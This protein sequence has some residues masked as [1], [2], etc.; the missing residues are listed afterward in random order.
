MG[1]SASRSLRGAAV[2]LEVSALVLTAC[3]GLRS[4]NGTSKTPAAVAGS[5][6]SGCGRQVTPGAVVPG[7]TENQMLTTGSVSGSYWLTV[8]DSCEENSSSA[9]AMVR[10]WAA[11]SDLEVRSRAGTAF[12]S[13]T[14]AWIRTV[15]ANRA[16]RAHR[17]NDRSLRDAQVRGTING[18]GVQ[19][20][21][22]PGAS[23][24]GVPPRT[25]G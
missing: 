6:S 21:M 25:A 5:P 12:M 16:A 23:T 15:P 3:T 18:S 1:E 2:G 20:G 13:T 24:L 10:V 8:P 9:T 22:M 4:S 11:E 14:M 19:N 17:A 7:S